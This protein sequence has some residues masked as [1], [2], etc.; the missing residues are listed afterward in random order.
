MSTHLKKEFAT[1]EEAAKIT[2][3]AYY[4]ELKAAVKKWVKTGEQTDFFYLPEFKFK[5]EANSEEEAQPLLW[6]G[7]Y[8][9]AWKKILKPKEK[10]A[11][12][13]SKGF[14]E[15]STGD[16]SG[17]EDDK[18]IAVFLLEE[19]T[20]AKSIIAKKVEKFAFKTGKVRVK[21]EV[22]IEDVAVNTAKTGDT[23]ATESS[24]VGASSTSPFRMLVQVFKMYQQ[25]PD[26]QKMAL[27]PQLSV[28][29][30]Q[31]GEY[32]S[33]LKVSEQSTNVS[34]IKEFV[35]KDSKARAFALVTKFEQDAKALLIQVSQP[36][37]QNNAEKAEPF[38][39]KGES[40]QSNIA[41]VLRHLQQLMDEKNIIT[42]HFGETLATYQVAGKLYNNFKVKFGEV[43]EK[44]AQIGGIIDTSAEL[45][46]AK[47]KISIPN[48][49]PS[50]VLDALQKYE[51]LL[52]QPEGVAVHAHDL[53][54]A[55]ML[56]LE[57]LSNDTSQA[58]E[59][60]RKKIWAA[61]EELGEYIYNHDNY[62]DIIKLRDKFNLAVSAYNQAT[63]PET[64]APL[65]AKVL[66]L[67]HDLGIEIGQWETSEAFDFSNIATKE[68]VKNMERLRVAITQFL[69][70]LQTDLGSTD[71]TA[72]EALELQQDA[73]FTVFKGGRDYSAKET[74]CIDK[75]EQAFNEGEE[76]FKKLLTKKPF[77]KTS[78]LQSVLEKI[79]QAA[80]LLDTW[81]NQCIRCDI[82]HS[83]T[84]NTDK[85]KAD[86]ISPNIKPLQNKLRDILNIMYS[87][88]AN[89]NHYT[90][91][92]EAI[93]ELNNKITQ[94]Q[95]ALTQATTP[96][97]REKR[98]LQIATLRSDVFLKE[99]QLQAANNLLSKPLERLNQQPYPIDKTFFVA[100]IVTAVD[101]ITTTNDTDTQIKTK[102]Q[103]RVSE[104]K[105]R[106]KQVVNTYEEFI[107]AQNS[108]T[109]TKEIIT[110]KADALLAQIELIERAIVA[111][112]GYRDKL[113]LE[114]PGYANLFPTEL[115]Q[116][117]ALELESLQYMRINLIDAKSN[118]ASSQ[119]PLRDELYNKLST[120]YPQAIASKSFDEI[121]QLR[122]QISP[123]QK[124]WESLNIFHKDDTTSINESGF[125]TKKTQ[126]DEWAQALQTNFANLAEQEGIDETHLQTVMTPVFQ[127]QLQKM[128]QSLTDLEYFVSDLPRRKELE[129]DIKLIEEAI[130]DANKRNDSVAAN[131][132]EEKRKEKAA[133]L[134]DLL[135]QQLNFYKEELKKAKDED[136]KKSLQERIA[137]R[138]RREASNAKLLETIRAIHNKYQD[139]LT[140]LALAKTGEPAKKLLEM[141]DAIND[142]IRQTV[143]ENLRD[144]KDA[145]GKFFAAL[146]EDFDGYRLAKG[147]HLDVLTQNK[148]DVMGEH[149]RQ[150][151]ER[152]LLL[153]KTG[154]D[155]TELRT[156]LEHLPV[157]VWPDDVLETLQA[158][159]IV[160]KKV[161]DN[162]KERSE[163]IA[164][165]Q[166]EAAQNMVEGVGEL[167]KGIN[168]L[169]DKHTDINDS[170]FKKGFDTVLDN[171]CN[172]LENAER[173]KNV[174]MALCFRKNGLLSV[175]TNTAEKLTYILT[176]VKTSKEI[177]DALRGKEDE[178]DEDS[179][180][181]KSDVAQLFDDVDKLVSALN[182]KEDEEE[183]D[184]EKSVADKVSD[185]FD[186]IL[187]GA[188]NFLE[189]IQSDDADKFDKG[190]AGLMLAQKIG[191]SV[192]DLA[193]NDVAKDYLEIIGTGLDAIGD[194]KDLLTNKDLDK[195]EKFV[196]FISIIGS[197]TGVLSQKDGVLEGTEAQAVLNIITNVTKTIKIAND[198]INKII[199]DEKLSPEQIEERLRQTPDALRSIKENV[200]KPVETVV[201]IVGDVNKVLQLF[202]VA[203][204]LAPG[205]SIASNALALINQVI[206]IAKTARNMHKHKQLQREAVQFADDDTFALSLQQN[207]NNDKVV[208]AQQAVDAFAT[209]VSLAGSIAEVSGADM[210]VGLGIK[211]TGTAIKIGSK[212]VFAVIDEV[213]VAVVRKRVKAALEGDREAKITIFRDS[214]F[215]AK[216]YV[217][218]LAQDGAT[219]N[220]K[221]EAM[222]KEFCLG[223]GVSDAE[224]SSETAEAILRRIFQ[225][226]GEHDDR[227]S[228]I[229][230]GVKGIIQAIKEKLINL[231]GT[232]WNTALALD[233]QTDFSKLNN[234]IERLDQELVDTGIDEAL[235]KGKKKEI[236]QV[237]AG[238]KQKLVQ[239]L[240]ELEKDSI[241][242]TEHAE[243]NNKNLETVK[244]FL[245]TMAVHGV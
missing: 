185:A 148:S 228:R 32:P 156:T 125:V 122:S 93:T 139:K 51:A 119:A 186:N 49:Y 78:S 41:G 216:M 85:L 77:T 19:G 231:K 201:S 233:L 11:A 210:G 68:R 167:Q 223:Y 158:W 245:K 65:A 130:A 69:E 91:I 236:S 188:L 90:D 6:I 10:F 235:R 17:D 82:E 194:T 39:I 2:A 30:E 162:A 175:E 237:L 180:A 121:Y 95:T 9:M 72:Q 98:I 205:L 197:I 53:Q 214:A 172:G 163:I 109:H 15:D 56:L 102:Q 244:G 29:L 161:R 220:K 114:N 99:E 84:Y 190:L 140:P 101:K 219:G 217:I 12:G 242:N 193:D 89:E 110:Q 240:V 143:Q 133:K 170:N 60:L 187:K 169:L 52:N 154:A 24:E 22:P 55:S 42:K 153:E 218:A 54:S 113:L 57:S 58:T 73:I 8:N 108:G 207:V 20:G 212:I 181:P 165:E 28:L 44:F 142:A 33:N 134:D 43:K 97:E 177:A 152:F 120:L 159:E 83:T 208:I 213:K 192:A 46:L 179:D 176:A 21:F 229:G 76:E 38:I 103:E 31:W 67:V 124:Y 202:D 81:V 129:E 137:I 3:E 168:D 79:N 225:Q 50:K 13:T 241:T 221:A 144:N 173:L 239:T 195:R 151:I 59:E 104:Y 238:L 206:D 149:G 74:K 189:K 126:I 200:I 155:A 166:K 106:Y 141:E 5:P 111:E 135:H 4:K 100:S 63:T 215:Y 66:P 127:S 16:P 191:V 96:E 47:L 112:D 203:V 94:A 62:Q 209:T 34:Q 230:S 18:K 131:M 123:T 243:R 35:H 184:E 1:P 160:T 116:D 226:T 115:S 25:A 157:S 88:K 75:A 138:E 150:I 86:T 107:N 45:D 26:T 198:A 164:Q 222:A 136:T 40:L 37:Q 87:F 71:P 211:L 70:T 145:E 80:T 36:L 182:P 183:D 224:L 64:K 199:G 171:F 174:M 146:G 92:S 118:V 27:L 227:Y 147:K 196:K 204:D 128:T 7:E 14:E 105:L 232:D 132:F 23:I 48:T 178:E 234:L 117:L 61:K